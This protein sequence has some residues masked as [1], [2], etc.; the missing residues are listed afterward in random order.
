M[1]QQRKKKL[2]QM[3]QIQNKKAQL[4]A[5]AANFENKIGEQI[6]DIKQVAKEK[7]TQILVAGAVVAGAYLLYS[8]MSG[9]DKSEKKS[10]KKESSFLGNAITS[11]A[12]G[13]ALSLAK[14][15][16]VDYLRKLEEESVKK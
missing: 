6:A 16:L 9:S 7:G 15:Q 11:Y 2:Q 13:I 12:V 3:S 8:L 4:E 10:A 1:K 5:E 14:D